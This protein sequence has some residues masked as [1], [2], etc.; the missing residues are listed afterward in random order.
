MR[1]FAKSYLGLIEGEFSGL[2]LTRIN[3]FEDFYSRQ[4][5]EAINSLECKMFHVELLFFS[6]I[7]NK[8]K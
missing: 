3:D 7:I 1:N 4:I 5:I 8:I 2:N 6:L